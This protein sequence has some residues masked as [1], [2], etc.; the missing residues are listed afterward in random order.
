MEEDLRGKYQALLDQNVAIGFPDR[1]KMERWFI[2]HIEAALFLRTPD[3]TPDMI[4]LQF[5]Q[6]YAPHLKWLG[7]PGQ[8]RILLAIQEHTGIDLSHWINDKSEE[9]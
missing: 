5:G 8:D 9:L 7:D 3:V 6:Y 4:I 1:D 2:E